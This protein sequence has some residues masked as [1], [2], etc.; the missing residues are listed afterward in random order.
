VVAR[1]FENHAFRASFATAFRQPTF[2]E[3]YMNIR[4]PVPSVNGA[5]VLTQGNKS[6]KPE[7]LISF[8]L[9]YRGELPRLGLTVDLAGYWNIVSDLIVLGGVQ[10]VNPESLDFPGAFDAQSQ[11]FL[12]GRSTFQNDSQTYHARGAE[13]G[14]T[15][16]ATKGLDLRLSTALQSIVAN[17]PAPGFVCGACTQSPA[18]KLNGGF[19]YR[20]PVNL[21]LSA[22]VS[23]VT[24]T[25]WV[26]REPSPQ[27][28][29]QITNLQNPLPNPYAVINARVAYR[30]F[31][32]KLTVAVV[33]S[34]LGPNHQEHPFGNY[35][36]RRVFAQITVQP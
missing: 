24:G 6:L 31:N 28:P 30:L 2:L 34:Q 7:R 25:V 27:D 23:L 13:L 29:T 3:S 11:S 10:P 19:I 5:S 12:L 1:P 20:T 9:G 21:D 26:E 22:D 35:V 8:E 36:N 16:N 33:G 17:N 14:V 15:W 32:D 18:L 4:T